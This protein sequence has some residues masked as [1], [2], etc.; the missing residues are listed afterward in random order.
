M[1]HQLKLLHG[2]ESRVIREYCLEKM[3]KQVIMAYFNILSVY[4]T[5]I[6]EGVEYLDQCMSV[7]VET[8]KL[9]A[10]LVSLFFPEK[11][12]FVLY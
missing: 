10:P 11:W 7:S 6:R 8:W 12:R 4:W 3:W 9:H 2:I 5:R 1:L